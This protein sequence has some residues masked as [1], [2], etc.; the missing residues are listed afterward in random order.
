MTVANLTRSVKEIEEKA[1]QLR[2]ELGISKIPV[3]PVLIANKLGIKVNLAAFNEDNIAGIIVRRGATKSIL[4][5]Y[6]DP[7]TRMR[8]TIAHEIGH[9]QLHLSSCEDS[10]EIV[11][12]DA[13]L[14]RSSNENT[15]GM[16]TEANRFAAALLMPRD[17][18]IKLWHSIKS[19]KEMA[20]IFQVSEESMGYRLEAL[21]IHD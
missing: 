14:Y 6:G 11:D 8:F 5:R 18:V 10:V 15:G 2:K 4:V 20:R 12:F 9:D 16:E 7:P 21:N 1:D 17:E 13:D 3:D 19:I